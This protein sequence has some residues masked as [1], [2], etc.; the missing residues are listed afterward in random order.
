MTVST[1][2]LRILEPAPHILAFYDGRI[3][4]TR[5]HA[6]GPNWLDDGAYTLG[7]ASYVVYD[8][9]EAL[10]FDTHISVA[11]ARAIRAELDRREIRSI[12]VVLSHFHRDH[13]AGSGIFTDC[14]ILASGKTAQV[15]EDNRASFADTTPS[16]DPLIM[17]T[18][19]FEGVMTLQVGDIDVEL[20][21]LDIHSFD[22]LVAYL[23]NSRTLLAGDTLEDTVTYVA[24]PD[25]LHIH[26]EELDRLATWDIQS[27][28]PNH[29]DPVRIANGGY[30]RSFISATRT[31]LQ[32][33]L[34]CRS[35]PELAVLGLREFVADDLTIGA[36]V[37]LDTYEN[38][39]RHNVQAVLAGQ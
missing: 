22:G 2:T 29:G 4:G 20:R 3:N 26:I 1:S 30:D 36:L 7:V 25:R 31:Y 17:P 28:L 16:I 38:V 13:V 18:T 27:I 35:Q 5:L 32:K 19:T 9:D 34:D 23:P 39:H 21:P 37:Y 11:H 10:V 12:R 6:D 8:G 15:L 33:L 24:E 14:E